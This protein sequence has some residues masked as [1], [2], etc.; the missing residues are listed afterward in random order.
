[1]R[2]FII[3]RAQKDLYLLQQEPYKRI[4]MAIWGLG[5][6]PRPNGC[7]KLIGREGWRIR[8]GDYRVIYERFI[9]DKRD[10]E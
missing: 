5:E 6:D 1:M 7:K 4:K 10:H 3:R 2:C 9:S 8:V